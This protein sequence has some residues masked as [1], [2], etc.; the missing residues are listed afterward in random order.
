MIKY[1]DAQQWLKER[2]PKRAK[3]PA[4]LVAIFVTPRLNLVS[5]LL[6]SIFSTS[7]ASA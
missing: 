3:F 2:Q 6:E 5:A 1:Y 4:V 7:A